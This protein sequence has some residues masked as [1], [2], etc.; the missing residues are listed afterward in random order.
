MTFVATRGGGRSG[1]PAASHHTASP[2]AAAHHSPTASRQGLANA[3]PI[4]HGPPAAEAG[5]LPWQLGAP[6]SREVVAPLSSGALEMVGG[7]DSSGAS[8]SGVFSLSVPGGTAT[9]LHGLSLGIHDA[10]GARLGD[11][12]LVFGGGDPVPSD[13]SQSL[14]LASPSSPPTPLG[15][16]PQPRSDTSAVTIGNTVYVVGGFTGS[17]PASSVLATSDGVNFRQVATLPVSVRYAAVVA[18]SGKIYVFGGL[19]VTGRDAGQPVNLVQ[20]VDPARGQAALLP[21]MPTALAG[22]AAG[23]AGG[24]LY[25]AGGYST[26]GGPP[27]TAIWAFDPSSGRLLQAGNLPVAVANAGATVVGSRLWLVGG[28]V[29]GGAPVADVQMVEPNPAFGTAGAPGAGSPYYGDK[30]LIADRGN[31]QLLL[32]NDSGQIVWRYP[33]PG[34]PPP[35]GGFYYPDDAFFARHGTDIVVNQ[36]DNETMVQLAYPSGR[37][38]WTYGHPRQAG[39]APGYLSNPDDAYLLNN[40]DVVVADIKNCRVLV[41]S[42][43]G[44][45]V[46]QLGTTGRC[47]HDPPRAL[48]SP[49]GDTPLT[50]GNLLVSE[51]NGS[52]VDEISLSGHLLWTAH[53]PIGYPSDPQQMGPD[54]YVVADYESPGAIIEFD[55]TGH[56]LYRYQPTAGPGVLNQPSLAEVLPSGVL[57]A[58]DDSNDRMVA[59]DPATSALVWQYGVTGTPGTSPGM[60]NT[61]DGFDILGPGGTT[62]TH[63]GTG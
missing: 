11:H 43:K 27:T 16:M 41:V 17:A 8:Q 20:V 46:G 4:P 12:L 51:I 52:F 29:A 26:E 7:L 6:V 53:L 37:V 31:N 25:V 34:A 55:R 56:V 14:N 44:A 15:H 33:S 35:P 13:L 47:V 24:T 59:I 42:P 45:V 18:L 9:P 5:L 50:D 63:P 22:A 54:R 28:E 39:S 1:S 19:A 36:E 48:G 61:P 30:L 49:N 10:A 62:P 57:M 40:G 21:A 32:L 38:I 2:G 60:L 58:N 23:V 3:V